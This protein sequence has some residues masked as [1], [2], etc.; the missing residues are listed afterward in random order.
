MPRFAVSFVGGLADDA[1][2]ALRGIGAKSRVRA[3]SS[4]RVQSSVVE[5]HAA[6]AD[7]AVAT[8][9]QALQPH[10]SFSGFQARQLPRA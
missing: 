6:D 1:T 2:D 9:R 5:L 4:V 10:G 8:V 7:V 3:K